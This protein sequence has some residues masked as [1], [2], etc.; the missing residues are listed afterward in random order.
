MQ[1]VLMSATLDSDLLAQY[2]GDCQTLAAG[3]HTHPVEQF[4]L[5][6]VFE[7]TEYRLDAEGPAA[8]RVKPTSSKNK[9]LQKTSTSKQKLVQV[10]DFPKLMKLQHNQIPRQSLQSLRFP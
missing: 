6:D 2:F 9:A 10:L 7:M 8:L 3:G 4:F 5:E 1:V